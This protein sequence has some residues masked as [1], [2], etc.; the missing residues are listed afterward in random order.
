MATVIKTTFKLRRGQLQEW[1]SKNPILA[2]G[3]PGFALD[4]NILK[5]GNG[6]NTWTEL[7]AINGGASISPDGSSITYDAAGSLIVM[8]FE[9]A[10]PGQIPIKDENGVLIWI[11]LS[12]VATS[13]LIDD[14]IQKE[15]IHLY[16]GSAP[17]YEEE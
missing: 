7:P 2:A 4:A 5:I 15:T 8:G 9:S 16:G 11:N 3:E 6:A 1:E 14:L 13:G 17:T 12:P 10:M